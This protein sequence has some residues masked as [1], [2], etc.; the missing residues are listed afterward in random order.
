MELLRGAQQEGNQANEADHFPFTRP[1]R[2][3]SLIE[4]GRLSHVKPR[5][6]NSI[7]LR[8]VLAQ[9]ALTG[10]QLAATMR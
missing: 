9:P 4:R 1:E 5:K 6:S 10:S 8:S 7:G 3:K 2:R